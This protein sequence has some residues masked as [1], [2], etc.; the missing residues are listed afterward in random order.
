MDRT[1]RL[2]DLVALFLDAHGPISWAELRRAFP[3]DYGGTDEAA[4]RKFERDKAE[5]LELGIPVSY[6]P[7]NDEQGGGY[8]VDRQAYYLP[9]AGL[10]PEEVAVLYAA[11]SAALAGAFPGTG[12]LAHALRK[13]GFLA[14]GE[15]PTPWLRT[16]LD[17]I[18][19]GAELAA[20]LEQLWSAAAARK[21]VDL[22]Y[23]SPRN[24][25]LT[26]RRVDPYGLALRRGIWSLVGRC[27]LRGGIRTFHVHRI[28]ELATNQTRPRSP[29]FEVPADFRP[30]AHVARYPWQHNFHPKVAVR[31]ELR[32]ELAPLAP[33]LFPGASSQASEERVMLELE[34]TDLEGLL[35]Y[36][37]SLGP[38]CRVLGPWE[39]VSRQREMA[40][41]IWESHQPP[42][43][44]L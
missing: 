30:E 41:R 21:S 16:E 11:G 2:L 15:L 19:H 25:E 4:E 23:Y 40:S 8:T 34:A 29:D 28:R 31:L 35:K 33:S 9:E 44:A 14:G 3:D 6:V 27:Q 36:A 43:E 18:H 39:A 12:D 7:P 24:G 38:S 42:G 20:R 37:L 5:L 17:S 22:T 26:R 10:S 1:E 13:I 32:E